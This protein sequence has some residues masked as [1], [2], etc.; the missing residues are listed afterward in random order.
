MRTRKALALACVATGMFAATACS[1][2]DATGPTAL[3]P[4]P[5]L[6]VAAA[7]P[8]VI[9][10]GLINIVISDVLNNLT[11]DVDVRDNNVAVQVCAIVELLSADLGTALQ[12]DIQ[13]GG[14]GGGGGGGAAQ[15]GGGSG[16]SVAPAQAPIVVGG[17]L[18]NIVVT[19]VLNDLTIDIDVQNNNVAVQVCAAVEAL[20]LTPFGFGILTC[21]INQQ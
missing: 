2:A 13:Q 12:C 5:S 9:G 3:A 14:G 10:G 19:D 18:V 8:I 20:N 7:A 1:D 6:A 4:S 16:G 21:E 11:V 17:G 15:Q